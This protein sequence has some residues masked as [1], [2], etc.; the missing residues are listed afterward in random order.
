MIHEL[1]HGLSRYL[2]KQDLARYTK[3]FKTA[4][5]KYLKQFEKEKTAFVRNNTPESLKQKIGRSPISFKYP[6]MVITFQM[7]YIIYGD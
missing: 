5:T 7:I 1:W 3:E 6:K 4:Q 2:P